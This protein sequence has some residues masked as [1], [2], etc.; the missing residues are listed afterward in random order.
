MPNDP[1]KRANPRTV[2]TILQDRAIRHALY[3]VRLAGG[4]AKWV[5]ENLPALRRAASNA[6]THILAEL[7]ATGVITATDEALINEAANRGAEAVRERL[8]ELAR[9]SSTRLG[10]IAVNEA[11]FERRLFQRAIPVEMNFNTPSD[12]FLLSM[13]ETE[14]IA[15]KSLNRWFTDMAANTRVA[16]NDQIRQGMIEGESIN[17]ILR[18]VRGRREN[19]YKDGVIGRVGEDAKALV[20]TGVMRASNRARNEFHQANQD[21]IKGY[22]VV[23]T[24][25]DRTCTQCAAME[26]DN[27]YSLSDKPEPPFHVNCRCIVATVTKSW[28]ELGIDLDEMEPGDRAAMDGEVPDDLTYSDWF[29]RQSESVQRDILG[30]S[31]FEAY[32]K[33]MDVTAFA[34]RGQILTI[35]QLRAM[36]PDLFD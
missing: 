32:K 23:L 29:D 15:G 2:N 5:D 27:P 20:R 25:D 19:A 17:N 26:A 16:L 6:I 1:R 14:P 13:M 28:E 34:D 33:G 3:V 12:R 18:R 36:E 31:R 22:Q 35:D 30:E 4:E 8:E 7:D 21:V 11:D 24:L 9:Q 10:Q